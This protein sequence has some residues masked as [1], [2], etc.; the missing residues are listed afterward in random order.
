MSEYTCVPS[1]YVK[2]LPREVP[3]EIGALVEPL[4]VGWHAV[5]T[6]PFKE[7]DS[8]LVLGG[9]PIGLAVILALLAKGC[10]NI[11]VAEVWSCGGLESFD[12]IFD[13]ITGIQE[14]AA[15]RAGFWRPPRH[16]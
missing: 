3:L 1:A 4:A 16:W 11:I 15:I 5:S 6:S 8:V 13:T 12:L 10:K 7:D 14:A 9:G 2:K